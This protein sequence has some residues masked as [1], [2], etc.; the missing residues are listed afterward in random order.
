MMVVVVVV[1]LQ[2]PSASKSTL[3]SRSTEKV[4]DLPP[5]EP[6]DSANIPFD[7]EDLAGEE[8]DWDLTALLD[9]EKQEEAELLRER[10]PCLNELDITASVTDADW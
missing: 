7:E 6:D 4:K 2:G 1:L 5:Q 10:G 9:D 8:E 3:L